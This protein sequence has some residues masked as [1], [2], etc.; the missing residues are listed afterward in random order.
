MLKS[1]LVL[2]FLSSVAM[3]G[4]IR[5]DPVDMAR[6]QKESAAKEEAAAKGVDGPVDWPP[7]GVGA[8]SLFLSFPTSS[9]PPRTN[10][11]S[12]Y[13]QPMAEKKHLGA[14]KLQWLDA[15]MCTVI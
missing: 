10:N 7:K 2:S 11:D 3:A 14:K 13:W 6:F 1:A 4:S 9:F 15:C 5:A 8:V 12:S